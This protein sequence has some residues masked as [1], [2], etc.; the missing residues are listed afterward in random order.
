ME[1]SRLLGCGLVGR[2]GQ[3]KKSTV[4]GAHLQP[5]LWRRLHCAHM[6]FLPPVSPLSVLVPSLKMIDMRVKWKGDSGCLMVGGGYWYGLWVL[7]QGPGC[8]EHGSLSPSA[9]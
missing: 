8:Q 6:I 1:Q 9:F 3:V 5:R 7:S 2:V 4:Q